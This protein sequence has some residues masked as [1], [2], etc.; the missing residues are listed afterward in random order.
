M[1]PEIIGGGGLIFLLIGYRLFPRLWRWLVRMLTNSALA[2]VGIFLWNQW[3]LGRGLAVGLNPVTA[4]VV[5][6]L[7]VPGFALVLAVRVLGV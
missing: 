6:V 3:A 1:A 2:V 7:G 5:G 4:L